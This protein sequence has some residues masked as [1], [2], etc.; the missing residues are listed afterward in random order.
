MEHLGTASHQ[1]RPIV[2]TA[3]EPVAPVTGH[4]AAPPLLPA[5][6]PA[7]PMVTFHQPAP[8]GSGSVFL[9]LLPDDDSWTTLPASTREAYRAQIAQFLVPVEGEA[10]AQVRLRQ[11]ISDAS[12]CLNCIEDMCFACGGKPVTSN[13]GQRLDYPSSFLWMHRIHATNLRQLMIAKRHGWRVLHNF[14][15]QVNMTSILSHVYILIYVSYNHCVS[16]SL[17]IPLMSTFQGFLSLIHI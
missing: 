9:P 14:Q 10:E 16:T 4:G 1:F 17:Y 7:G 11:R 3:A 6:E 5:S 8:T 13:S 12:Q 15:S 2:A